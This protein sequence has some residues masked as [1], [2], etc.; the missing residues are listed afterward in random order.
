MISSKNKIQ[1]RWNKQFKI[2]ELPKFTQWKILNWIE[3]LK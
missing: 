2:N 3:K 1:N